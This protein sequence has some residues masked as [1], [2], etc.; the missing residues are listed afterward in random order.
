MSRP[1]RGG[2]RLQNTTRQHG[3]GTGFYNQPSQRDGFL[4]QHGS[5]PQDDS[6]YRDWIDDPYYGDQIKDAVDAA[7]GNETDS[8]RDSPQP[9]DSRNPQDSP[10]PRDRE[11]EQPAQGEEPNLGD[12]GSVG[13]GAE[14]LEV[15][16]NGSIGV[17]VSVDVNP[18]NFDFNLNDDGSVTIGAG[19]QIPGR[20][21]GVGGGVTVDADGNVI[22]G[23]ASVSAG[24]VSV[25]IGVEECIAT[26]GLGYSIGPVTTT[27]TYSHNICGDDEPPSP[28]P[29][30]GSNEPFNPNR[31]SLDQLNNLQIDP[32]C[33]TVC[34]NY[35]SYYEVYYG[36]E[37]P[38]PDI[39]PNRFSYCFNP[40]RG[41][42]ISE[43]WPDIVTVEDWGEYNAWHDYFSIS[44]RSNC[45]QYPSPS[46]SPSP[47]Y[48]VIPPMNEQCCDKLFALMLQMFITLGLPS[49]AGDEPL[50]INGLDIN[51]DDEGNS[52]P[53]TILTVLQ[54]QLLL[55]NHLN[56]TYK[57]LDLKELNSLGLEIPNKNLVPGGSGYTTNKTYLDILASAVRERDYFGIQSPLKVTI[58]DTNNLDDRQTSKD[59]YYATPTAMMQRLLDLTLEAKVDRAS[60]T[61]ILFRLGIIT[62][63]IAIAI[64]KIHKAVLAVVEGL[65]IPVRTRPSSVD[66]P[67]DPALG[68]RPKEGKTNKNDN[69]LEFP[70]EE[71]EL[72]KLLPKLCPDRSKKQPVGVYEVKP[73]QDLRQLLVK[74]IQKL[75]G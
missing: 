69:A 10:S 29:G 43:F 39:Y 40:L 11:R 51:K 15:G 73:H 52:Q 60:N 20:M 72:E 65:G 61:N 34:V 12:F 1:G 44:S 6:W 70:D 49:L 3:E 36:Q 62:S 75:G 2:T 5:F 57:G 71:E 46:P 63:Q 14:I 17:S 67:F 21:L 27:V 22:G 26:I 66:I 59:E 30:E 28:D 55:L 56:E 41:W 54:L 37:P 13:F 38:P 23:N 48:S 31:F 74:L 18:L 53:L 24:G 16:D 33:G 32:A 7:R 35:W 42:Y 68:Y 8:P 9:R 64:E 4:G 45:F 47:S 25:S 58:K 19:A 50:T